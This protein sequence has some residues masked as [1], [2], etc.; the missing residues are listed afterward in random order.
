MRPVRSGF[1]I[2]PLRITSEPGTSRA[3]TSGNAAEDG[4]AGTVTGRGASSGWPVSV[5]R[6]PFFSWP[7]TG[8]TGTTSTRTWA[9]KWA[10]IFS[11]WS[12]VGSASITTVSP[13][14]ESP[15]KQRRRLQLRRRNRRLEHDRHRIARARERQRQAAVRRSERARADALQ[16]IEHALHRPAAQRSIA[17]E[18]RRNRAAGDGAERKPAA[19]S[20]IA[21]IECICR[22]GKAA[23]ADAMDQ[24][25]PLAGALDAGAKRLQGLRRVKDV[26]AFEQAADPGL[27]DRERAENTAL[28]SRSTC[29]PA[30]ARRRRA[31]RCGGR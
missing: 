1:I 18:R 30:R 2:T 9:P 8:S 20:G 26:L 17:V 27:A 5:M 3:A 13:G 15:A 7:P 16:R 22:L 28:E 21:E 4:S 19:G 11:V 31:D 10:S 23:D 12:R 14:A 24:P 25:L 6:R 29:R